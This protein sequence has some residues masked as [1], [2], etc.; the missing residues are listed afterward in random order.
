MNSKGEGA[1]LA[2]MIMGMGEEKLGEVL[3]QLLANERFVGALQG[4][5]TSSLSAKIAMDKN[6]NRVFGIA[7]VPTLEDVDAVRDK[8]EDLEESLFALSGALAG[9]TEKVSA[10]T[11]QAANAEKATKKAPAA[12]KKGAT[13]KKGAKKAPAKT[14]GDE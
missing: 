2:Q 4:A 13:R 6:L 7:N 1:G 12:R 11:S 5:V 10:L 9:L 8:L 3:T 14:A